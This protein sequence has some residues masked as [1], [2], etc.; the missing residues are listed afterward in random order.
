M[1]GYQ[2]GD[3][4][5]EDIEK[6]EKVIKRG[7]DKLILHSTILGI[8]GAIY[9]LG[10]LTNNSLLEKLGIGLSAVASLYLLKPLVKKGVEDYI[11]RIRR[12]ETLDYYM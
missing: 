10:N 3:L 1:K 9:S 12:R 8:G 2:D 7:M 4:D 5:E 11:P 6:E